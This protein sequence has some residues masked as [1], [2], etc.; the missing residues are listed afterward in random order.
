MTLV[1]LSCVC[2]CSYVLFGLCLP[3]CIITINIFPSN[4][5][6]LKGGELLLAP[7]QK[8]LCLNI[9][10]YISL[11]RAFF[12]RTAESVSSHLAYANI[13]FTL[14]HTTQKLSAQHIFIKPCSLFS[15]KGHVPFSAIQSLRYLLLF[16]LVFYPSSDAGQL[17]L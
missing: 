13:H 12:K 1:N 11:L 8:G 5:G 2:P 14:H 3:T 6:W 9:L 15:G 17:Y 10:F 4:Y 7:G 16:L